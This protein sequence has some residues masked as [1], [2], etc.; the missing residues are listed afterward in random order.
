MYL[1]ETFGVEYSMWK[2]QPNM[3]HPNLISH[4]SLSEDFIIPVMI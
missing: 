3:S 1:W 4:L 2:A